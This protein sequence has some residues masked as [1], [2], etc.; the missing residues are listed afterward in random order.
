MSNAQSFQNHAKFDPLFHF[1]LAPVGLLLLVLAIVDAVRHPN[2]TN[3][4]H[5]FVVLWLVLLVFKTR[6]YA[7]KNQ[8]RIIRLEQRVRLHSLLPASM[9]PR[10]ADL[11]IDQL[12]GLRFAS[13]AELPSL[14][15]K[16]LSG[17][18]D[19]NQIKGAV[20]NWQA[21]DWRV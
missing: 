7:L 11:S 6:L 1:F 8:D 10:I 9:Q 4:I 13:D 15:E 12:I 14:V 20:Q 19:R 5:A 17:N 18:W 3:G 2:W 21:D 16:T